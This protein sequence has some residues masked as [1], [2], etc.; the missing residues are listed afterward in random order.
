MGNQDTYR[1]AT[2][3]SVAGTL[4]MFGQICGCNLM[5]CRDFSKARKQIFAGEPVQQNTVIVP[6][7][8]VRAKPAYMISL[9]PTCGGPSTPLNF[10]GSAAWCCHA[11]ASLAAI[12]MEHCV[13]D[14]VGSERSKNDTQRV[15]AVASTCRSSPLTSVIYVS[16]H[17]FW[18]GLASICCKSTQNS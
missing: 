18:M 10:A 4:H 1:L 12:P 9:V 14:M 15:Y 3:D 7:D 11:S 2:L 8:F 16:H 17:N 13:N 6:W 5:F